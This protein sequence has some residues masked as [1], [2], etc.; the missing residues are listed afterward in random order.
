LGI[1]FCPHFEDRSERREDFGAI[2][3]EG[4]V[5]VRTAHAGGKERQPA[6]EAGSI[7]AA[8]RQGGEENFLCVANL[9]SRTGHQ[10][11][12]GEGSD[13]RAPDR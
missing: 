11:R 3:F 2:F 5:Q 13:R 10:G 7:A 9:F 8:E 1:R 6:D 4:F 12:D